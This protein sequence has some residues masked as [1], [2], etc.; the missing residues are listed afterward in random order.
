M[1]KHYAVIRIRGIIGKSRRVNDTLRMIGLK[2]NHSMVILSQD[3]LPVIKSVANYVTWG[4]AS[5][6]MA[7][8]F[9]KPTV[10]SCPRKGFKATKMIYPKGDLG[11]R[12]DKINELI[13]RMLPQ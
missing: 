8:K 2:R 7:K 3:K 6:T 11:Y 5:G 10:L 9:E 13:E 12:G 1:E 4:E